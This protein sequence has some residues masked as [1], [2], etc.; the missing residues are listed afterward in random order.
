MDFWLFTLS[1][2][3]EG[4]YFV[5]HSRL[6]LRPGFFELLMDA[7]VP[8]VI[9]YGKTDTGL[10]RH[11][12]ED[13][14]LIRT[15]FGLSVLA[16]GMGGAAAGELA[17]QIFAES[18]LEIFTKSPSPATEEEC[19]DLLQRCYE[20][21]NERI[22]NHVMEYPHHDGMGCTAEL[23]I[24][25]DEKFAIGHVGDSRTY[26]FRKGHL[27]QLTKD[28]S[29]VQQQVDQGLISPDEAR[30]HRLRNVILRAVGTK[31]TLAVDFVRGRISVGDIFL[32]CSD[33]LT[34]MIEDNAIQEIL[35]Q[36][37]GIEAKAV[38]LVESAKSAGGFDNVT[39]VLNEVVD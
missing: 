6:A 21:A 12:N 24:F 10:R 23:M 18:S 27:K 2:C 26:L 29:L 14:F 8:K 31:E 25:M 17:S 32:L 4:V 5:L 35:S 36:P 13:A 11:N 1:E 20:L 28:H 30:K 37:L 19:L 9:T 39:V 16:D 7:A 38:S 34:D 22:L 3:A 15:E 33:G